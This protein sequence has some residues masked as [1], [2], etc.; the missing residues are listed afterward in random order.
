VRARRPLKCSA[1]VRKAE[2]VRTQESGIRHEQ[3]R[4]KRKKEKR[5]LIMSLPPE[6]KGVWGGHLGSSGFMP[7]KSTQTHRTFIL[8]DGGEEAGEPPERDGS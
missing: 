2:V 8:L 3:R 1:C 7:E 6:K 4:K 5:Q